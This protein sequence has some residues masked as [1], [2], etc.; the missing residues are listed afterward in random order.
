M[1]KVI[2]MGRLTKDPE[3]KDTQDRMIARY[4]L[5]VDRRSQGEADFIQCVTFGKS[6][7]FAEKWLRRGMKILV[8]GKIRSDSYS[9]RDGQKIYT[10]NVIVDDQEF[11]ESSR[12]S[13]PQEAPG[14]MTIPEDDENTPFK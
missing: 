9:G 4:T 7:Q 2:L 6:A 14:F 5:A 3:I 8:T 13:Y 1:N 12:N 10:T 11:A